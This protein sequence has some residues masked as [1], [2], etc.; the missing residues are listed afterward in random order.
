MRK[1]KIKIH[2]EAGYSLPNYQSKDASGCDIIY[3]GEQPITLRSLDRA[4]IKSGISIQLP[5]GYE[6][7]VRSR[8]GLNKNHWIVCITGTIDSDYRGDIGVIL[9]N[10]SSDPYTIYP[11]DRIAQLVVC[12][13]IQADWQ[14]VDALKTFTGMDH[15]N[16][17]GQ[18]MVGMGIISQE[19]Q[20]LI[21]N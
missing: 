19:E 10:L 1:I 11:G 9:Y 2:V 15:V 18:L 7:Q 6:A 16:S 8:S 21:G 4:F 20:P 17:Q 5:E 3:S 12:P 14:Q 13:V